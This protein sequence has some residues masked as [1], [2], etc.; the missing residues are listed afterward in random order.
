MDILII[1]KSYTEGFALHIAET[2]GAMGHTVRRFEPGFKSNRIGGRIGHQLDQ[3][4]S[5][6]H[7]ASDSIPDIRAR[8]MRALWQ[9]G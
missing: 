3:V 5:V 6:I 1:G 7:S 4:R 2:L 8:R 9:G